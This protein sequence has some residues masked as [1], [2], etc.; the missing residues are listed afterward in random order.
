MSE[1]TIFIIILIINAI[2]SA[3]YLIVKMIHSIGNKLHKRLTEDDI[4]EIRIF[5]SDIDNRRT[6][7][8]FLI[9][10]FCPVIG[11][12]YVI[13]SFFF[14]KLFFRKPVDLGDVLFNKEH[15]K[16]RH[17]ANVERESNLVP[18][19]EALMVT[20]EKNLR[21]LMLS[22]LK[23]D[24]S[25]SLNRISEA[26]D[27]SDSE[28]AHYAASV[29]RDELNNFRAE[30]TR[31]INRLETAEEDDVVKIGITMIEYMNPFLK[32]KVFS[33]MEQRDYVQ[34][35]DKAS[36]DVF[37][38][39]PEAMKP[40]YYEWTADRLREAGLYDR[41]GIW[42]VRATAAYPEMLSSYTCRLKLYFET[43]DR[44]K[45]MSTLKELKE[46]DV[47]IDRDT[48]ELIR[49][50]S[51]D[52]F[53]TAEKPE[54]ELPERS[55]PKTEP[56]IAAEDVRDNTSEE[57]RLE[58]ALIQAEKEARA[59]RAARESRY[60]ARLPGKHTRRSPNKTITEL[61]EPFFSKNIYHRPYN[62]ARYKDN[63]P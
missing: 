25:N 40:E 48:L 26:L 12:V 23:G 1:T 34:I 59:A 2:W 49:V 22:V 21:T 6:V 11:P 39:S 37:N 27:S 57:A 33:E 51:T 58:R 28:T 18:I 16:T 52:N 3:A 19:E 41:S 42:C 9:Q 60:K 54:E 36:E 14:R 63:L 46:S 61:D 10:L 53:V 31:M 44:N 5:L 56:I 29:L 47:V 15:V 24:I 55:E 8:L 45:F 20:D 35:M 32:Q 38:A 13:F 7:F 17:P 4:K 43:G 30:V 62:P 50:F